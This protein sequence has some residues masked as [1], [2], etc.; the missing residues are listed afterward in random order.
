MTSLMDSSRMRCQLVSGTEE[1]FQIP[2]SEFSMG[3]LL[4]IGF[5]A[6]V[7]IRL[8]VAKGRRY[9]VEPVV[10]DGDGL[11]VSQFRER[12]HVEAVVALRV[13]TLRSGDIGA[14]GDGFSGEQADAR[15]MA[16][17][18]QVVA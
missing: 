8:Q 9:R 4:E 5:V 16:A 1:W 12:L 3:Q 18:R 13:V 15:V 7:V 10:G 6:N 14:V 11:G 2:A 17:F